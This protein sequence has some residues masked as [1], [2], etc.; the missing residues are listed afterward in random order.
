MQQKKESEKK[1]LLYFRYVVLLF[2]EISFKKYTE[3]KKTTTEKTKHSFKFIYLNKLK[4][5]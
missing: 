1:L 4:T 2:S 3:R 5:A